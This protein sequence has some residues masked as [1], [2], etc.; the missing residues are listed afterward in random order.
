MNVMCL[1]RVMVMRVGQ[2]VYEC[3][4]CEEDDGDEGG[5]NSV[6]MRCV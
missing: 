4:V 5:T 6:R 3:D 2:T 1:R